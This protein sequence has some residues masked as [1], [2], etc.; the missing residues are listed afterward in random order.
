M[1]ELNF[2]FVFCEKE[3]V[4]LYAYTKEGAVFLVFQCNSGFR[5]EEEVKKMATFTEEEK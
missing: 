1:S 3:M 4:F 5:T 2:C